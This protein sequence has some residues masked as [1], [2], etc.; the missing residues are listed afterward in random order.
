MKLTVKAFVPDQN[1]PHV[2][3]TPTIFI[4]LAFFFFLIKKI[5][6]IGW[7]VFF[8]YLVHI[9]DAPTIHPCLTSIIM[10]AL[11]QG[12]LTQR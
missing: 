8:C 6:V 7:S 12:L 11:T 9:R 5:H 1:L 10:S 4:Y 2:E 3:E